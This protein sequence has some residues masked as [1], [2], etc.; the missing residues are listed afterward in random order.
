MGDTF[1]ERN[2]RHECAKYA[3]ECITDVVELSKKDSG[4][5]KDYR[6]EVL[7][8]GTRIHNAGLL[9]TLTFYCSKIKDN[10]PH[11]ERLS[12]HIMEWILRN[13]KTGVSAVNASSRKDEGK[14]LKLLEF[15]LDQPDNRMI[16]FTREAMEVTQ[17][18][19]RFA[20]ARLEKETKV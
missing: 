15:L 8:T 17:W 7:S 10:K 19:K 13:E 14:P 6:S 12:S 18:L 2:I 5:Q 3:Y 16:Y 9:Q 4:I 11:F 20:E 1:Q